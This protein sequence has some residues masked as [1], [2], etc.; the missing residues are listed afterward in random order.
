MKFFFKWKWVSLNFDSNFQKNEIISRNDRE[1]KEKIH[2]IFWEV[3]PVPNE[4]YSNL[5]Y[6]MTIPASSELIWSIIRQVVI[7]IIFIRLFFLMFLIW[8]MLQLS[9]EA[10]SNF[11]LGKISMQFQ[12]RFEIPIKR[13]L[14]KYNIWNLCYCLSNLKFNFN[15]KSNSC[16][17]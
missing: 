4:F 7:V 3:L 12:L 9:L 6:W 8:H 15:Y 11:L 1:V 17:K 5:L 10:N 16:L 2:H 13:N 14:S